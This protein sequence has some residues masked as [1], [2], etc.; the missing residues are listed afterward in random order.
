MAAGAGE[1]GV[2][3]EARCTGD[4]TDERG[5]G[6]GSE[7]GLCEQLRRDLGDG[8]GDPCLERVDRLGELGPEIV[9][10]P[11]QRVVE[12]DARPDQPFAMVDKQPDV[13]LVRL[14]S[15]LARR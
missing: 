15:V 14:R 3:G 1:L 12:P 13:E 11:L 9:R 8:R 10:V 5:S 7:P 6:Q 2:G 4:L